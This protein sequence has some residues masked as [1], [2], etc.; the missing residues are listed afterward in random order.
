MLRAAVEL[1]PD[2]E[3]V[4]HY[5]HEAQ[6]LQIRQPLKENPATQRQSVNRD[7][8]GTRM[9]NDDDTRVCSHWPDGGVERIRAAASW[10]RVVAES[11][12]REGPIEAA[13][14]RYTGCIDLDSLF[15]EPTGD[16]AVQRMAAVLA[17]VQAQNQVLRS[18][19]DDFATVSEWLTTTTESNWEAARAMRQLPGLAAAI[20]ESQ[21]LIS[22]DSFSADASALVAAM[23]LRAVKLLDRLPSEPSAVDLDSTRQHIGGQVL[24]PTSELLDNAALLATNATRF[25]EEFDQRWRQMRNQAAHAVASTASPAVSAQPRS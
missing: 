13:A 21:R 16:S 17:Q 11:L 8:R 5:R 4:R 12:T 23:L 22:K 14:V 20:G 15:S 1:D 18:L 2:S 25:V 24:I 19:A 3:P 7:G 10:L 9:A 6:L